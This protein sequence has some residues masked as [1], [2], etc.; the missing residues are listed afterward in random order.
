MVTLS[1]TSLVLDMIKPWWIW[2]YWVSPLSYGQNAISVNEFT[3]R[4]WMEV[5]FFFDID[6]YSYITSITTYY[7]TLQAI[8]VFFY[9]ACTNC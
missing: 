9:F 5:F 4:R 6:V 8:K 2:A 1:Y 3:A 7:D